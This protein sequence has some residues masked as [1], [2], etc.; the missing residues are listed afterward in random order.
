[1]KQNKFAIHPVFLHFLKPS[2]ESLYREYILAR[3]LTFTRIAWGIVI[4]LAAVFSLLDRHFFGENAGLVLMFRLGIIFVAITALFFSK[5]KKLTHLM[6]WNGFV[7]VLLL[8]MFCHALVLLDTT[9]GFS[10][11]FTGLFLIFPGVFCTTGIGFR[12]SVF[13]LILVSFVFDI[14]FGIISPI[15]LSLFVTY[16]MFLGGMLL[17]YIFLSFIVET[18]F[19]K[20]Y[21]TSEK[22]RDSLNEVRQLSGLLPICAKCKKIR[23]DKGYWQQVETYIQAHS[24]AE[25]SHGM[26]PTCLEDVYGDKKWYQKM[27]KKN[28]ISED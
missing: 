9:K 14:L 10:I 21:I 25:F 12:F 18:I 7:F 15:Q 23:D 13:A 17:I 28:E 11:Y 5:N 16:N 2:T 19:R 26:C 20:N 22:L 3:N 8:G 1:M 6:D 24:Q 27:K 4:V